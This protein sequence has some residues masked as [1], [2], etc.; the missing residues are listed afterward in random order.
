MASLWEHIFRSLKEEPGETTLFFATSHLKSL[1]EHIF[2]GFTSEAISLYPVWQKTAPNGSWS[3]W[4]SL[5][6]RGLNRNRNRNPSQIEN[7]LNKTLFYFLYNIASLSTRFFT[8]HNIIRPPYCI[9][10]HNPKFVPSKKTS[11]ITMC[12]RWCPTR[13]M[14]SFRCIILES[15]NNKQSKS[16]H[17]KRD[18]KNRANCR[19]KKREVALAHMSVLV[20]GVPP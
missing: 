5:V 20:L 19:A 3:R 12:W 2:R 15:I 17:T 7:K 18:K 9:D 13:D 11:P 16:H 8:S 4:G 14:S 6:K 1:W 10:A